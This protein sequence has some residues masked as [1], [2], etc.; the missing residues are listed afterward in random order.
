MAQA[1]APRSRTLRLGAS[2]RQAL[3]AMGKQALSPEEKLTLLKQLPDEQQQIAL[4]QLVHQLG[5]ADVE[6]KKLELTNKELHKLI[7]ELTQQ[8]LYLA[9]FKHWA[10]VGDSQYALVFC[11][12]EERLVAISPDVDASTLDT[13]DTVYLSS[14]R[15]TVLCTGKRVADHAGQLGRVRDVYGCNGI[16]VSEH[17]VEVT[18]ER[19]HWLKDKKIKVGDQIVWCPRNRLVL[20]VIESTQVPGVEKITRDIKNPPPDFAGYEDICD[21][22]INGF[23][24][25]LSHPETAL[26]YGINPA[27]NALLLY[28]PSGCGKTLLA[29]NLAYQIGA[30]FFVINASAIYSPWVGESERQLIDA[31]RNARESAPALLFID[32]IDA[33]GRVR[34]GSGQQHSD[35]VAS[36]LL[37]QMDGAAGTPGI[38]IIGAC[39]RV[40]LLDSALTSR[41]SRRFMLRAPK[42]EALR[43]IAQVHFAE[44]YPYRNG[45]S[46]ARCI[47]AMID[48]LTSPNADN[49]IAT[50]RFRDG[51]TREIQ[52]RD[53]TSG[54]AVK[55]IVGAACE[56]AFRNEAQHNLTGIDVGDVQMALE[57]TILR[58]RETLCVENIR[59]YVSDLPDDI[60]IVAVNPVTDMARPALYLRAGT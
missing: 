41:F 6:L 30:K 47:D 56:S 57:K 35:R 37:T 3:C 21:E 12:G 23:V 17:D 8:P 18:L 31:F 32:E 54:R 44:H 59:G 26:R 4:D 19:A 36:V 49:K 38:G 5:A 28:G 2:I 13:G 55:Q 22:V 1:R 29:R 52:A 51:K 33:I 60:D 39:N 58:W 9:T 48:G 46:R 50:I 7:Q 24:T 42:R 27:E 25:A 16:I 15:N 53:L 14:E 11:N 20:N 43:A 34:G 10:E 45:N 40:D